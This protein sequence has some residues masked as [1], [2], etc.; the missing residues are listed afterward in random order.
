MTLWSPRSAIRSRSGVRSLSSKKRR[1]NWPASQ[2][3]FHSAT[4]RCF[5]VASSSE[6]RA[7]SEREIVRYSGRA[8]A[9]GRTIAR[10]MNPTDRFV[11]RGYWSGVE[12]SSVAIVSSRRNCAISAT[13]S[14]VSSSSFVSTGWSRSFGGVCVILTPRQ[15][16]PNSFRSC[17]FACPGGRFERQIR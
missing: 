10:L 4:A 15:S 12:C 13:V 16:E 9:T 1:L 14:G 3:M 7:S 6:C 11:N 8:N 17:Q 5:R 2:S